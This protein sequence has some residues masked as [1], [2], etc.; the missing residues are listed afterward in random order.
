[1]TTTP[2]KSMDFCLAC[3]NK[4]LKKS[5]INSGDVLLV[6]GVKP[7]PAKR[8]DPY[9]QRIYVVVVKVVEGIVQIPKEDNE[10]KAI[11]VDPRNLTL[12]EDQKEWIDKMATQ[13]G[14][15][16]NTTN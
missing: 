5:G 13:F 8:S 10:Y 11:V 4:G 1:M 12:I 15:E 14:G 6:V 16:Y 9:L 2:I 7:A 3:S